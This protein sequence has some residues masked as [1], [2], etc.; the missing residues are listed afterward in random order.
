MAHMRNMA[1]RHRRAARKMSAKL[2]P[3]VHDYEITDPAHRPDLRGEL[4]G[5]KVRQRDNKQIVTLSPKAAQ[6]YL[7]SGS[8]RPLQQPKQ[9]ASEQTTQNVSFNVHNNGRG[10]SPQSDQARA[11]YNT[12]G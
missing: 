3:E 10:A 2:G 8:I 4:A 7:D 1:F 12:K 9:G 5:A 6:F 11:G